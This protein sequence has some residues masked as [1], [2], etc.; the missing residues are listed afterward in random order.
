MSDDSELVCG[1]CGTT[2]DVYTTCEKCHRD[3]TLYARSW[4]RHLI[5]RYLRLQSIATIPEEII[6]HI[7]NGDVNWHYVK[8][9]SE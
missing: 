3:S 2:E 7:E 6:Q 5:V 9:A 1:G 8:E 4:E